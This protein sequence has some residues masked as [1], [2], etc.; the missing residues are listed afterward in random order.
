MT[1]EV[2]EFPLCVRFSFHLSGN[3]INRKVKSAGYESSFI[4]TNTCKANLANA[5]TRMEK[6]QSLMS[7]LWYYRHITY[8]VGGAR[9]QVSPF[10]PNKSHSLYYLSAPSQNPRVTYCK[11]IPV[12]SGNTFFT[13]KTLQKLH[14]EMYPPTVS[15]SCVFPVPLLRPELIHSR[16]RGHDEWM[17]DFPNVADT[18]PIPHTLHQSDLRKLSFILGLYRIVKNHIKQILFINYSITMKEEFFCC[19]ITRLVQPKIYRSNI[20]NGCFGCENIRKSTTHDFLEKCWQQ[21]Q[22]LLTHFQ[23]SK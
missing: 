11:F 20:H 8:V 4:S 5:W 22:C 15:H 9:S 13:D 12:V 18:V 21:P 10:N 1:N 16:V 17:Y 7:L 3:D 6:A 14:S 19:C 2:I 23:L